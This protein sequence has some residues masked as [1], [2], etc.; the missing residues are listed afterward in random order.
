MNDRIQL[1]PKPVDSVPD[2]L[3]WMGNSPTGLFFKTDADRG[4]Y[5]VVCETR[6]GDCGE[7]IN[8]T[9]FELFHRLWVS[10][11]MIFG[12][13]N[14][15]ATFKRNAMAMQEELLGHETKS[16]FD[17]DIG[18]ASESDFNGLRKTWRWLLELA[19]K[20]G[21]KFKPVTIGISLWEEIPISVLMVP[22]CHG[23]SPYPRQACVQIPEVYHTSQWCRRLG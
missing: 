20:H 19:A 14:G 16:Y 7:S 17:N 5:Q 15:P 3:A 12:Q 2:M 8:S 1:D 9:C 11:R 18:K 4:F 6:D 23:H 22:S 10:G 13:K 21:W